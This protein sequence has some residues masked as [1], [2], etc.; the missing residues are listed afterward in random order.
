MDHEFKNLEKAMQCDAI[1]IISLHGYLSKASDWAYYTTGDRE[2]LTG[3]KAA[4]KNVM[5]EEW[6]CRQNSM[7][8]S[9]HRSRSSM[10]PK[11]PGQAF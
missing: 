4:G 8:P 9:I 7:T 11:F 1:D 5:I 6:G 3:A 10:T 2:V